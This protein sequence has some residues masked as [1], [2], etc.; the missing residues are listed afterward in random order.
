MREK[1]VSLAIDGFTLIELLIVVSVIGILA[2]ALMS[3]ITQS[4]KNARLN[5][6]KVSMKGAMLV[7][8]ACN[9]TNGTVN[10]PLSTGSN[11]I[12]SN[13]SATYWPVL[14][15]SYSYVGGTYTADCDFTIKTN[16]DSAD[17][18]CTCADQRC[19]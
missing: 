4:R 18:R 7:I 17:I 5:N 13:A 12:C 3:N 14:Q 11:L 16:G 9:D 19:S 1:K 2:I 10:P 15:G 8:I 6:S